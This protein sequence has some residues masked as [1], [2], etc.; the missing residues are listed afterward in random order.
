MVSEPSISSS[1]H[2]GALGWKV[3]MGEA[4]S[5]EKQGPLAD[6]G[7]LMSLSGRSWNHRANAAAVGMQ[8]EAARKGDLTCLLFFPRTQSPLMPP[9]R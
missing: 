2:H 9:I 4:V 8:P 1:Q 7:T 5:A 3:Q 6:T